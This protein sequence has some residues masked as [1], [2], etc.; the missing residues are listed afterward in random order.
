MSVS[1]TKID[2][3]VRVLEKFQGVMRD[4]ADSRVTLENKIVINRQLFDM[5]EQ[6]NGIY[7]RL[8]TIKKL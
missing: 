2:R 5:N 6:V 7:Q 8:L 4:I 3:A 1:E